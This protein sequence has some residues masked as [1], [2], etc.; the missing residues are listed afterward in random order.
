MLWFLVKRAIGTTSTDEK[1][2]DVKIS[3]DTLIFIAQ[4]GQDYCSAVRNAGFALEGAK[5]L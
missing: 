4:Q 1:R 3:R 2:R 5:V